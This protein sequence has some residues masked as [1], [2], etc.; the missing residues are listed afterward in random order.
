MNI[1]NV[2]KPFPEGHSSWSTREITQERNPVGCGCNRCRGCSG[3]GEHVYEKLD[4]VNISEITWSRNVVFVGNPFPRGDI[5]VGFKE[6][7]W[8]RNL[9]F[10]MVFSDQLYLLICQRSIER[11]P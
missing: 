1:T 2:G 3:C 6:F 9:R 10:R 4:L 7:P 8:D 11:Q 5:P